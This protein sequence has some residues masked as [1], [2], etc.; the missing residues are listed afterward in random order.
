MV[1]CLVVWLAGQLVG[2]SF[3]WLVSVGRWL[4]WLVGIRRLVGSLVGWSVGRSVG[5]RCSLVGRLFP[6]F[7]FFVGGS[8]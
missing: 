1:G 8:F 4:G 2:R 5:N 6:F 3:G 7:P